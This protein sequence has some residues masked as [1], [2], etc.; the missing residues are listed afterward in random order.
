MNHDQI[1]AL[2]MLVFIG[3]TALLMFLAIK[4]E[5]D[6]PIFETIFNVY[7]LVVCAIALL[8]IVGLLTTI[9]IT[10]GI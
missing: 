1:A 3:K 9:L 10:G 5:Y 2:I 7:W 4:Y 8:I 6:Y